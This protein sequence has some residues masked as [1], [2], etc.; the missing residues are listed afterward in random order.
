MHEGDG[1][2]D[3]SKVLLVL[4]PSL[5]LCLTIVIFPNKILKARSVVCL[6]TRTVFA[7]GIVLKNL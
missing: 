2:R 5:L 6:Y 1:L 4:M 7:A 3:L